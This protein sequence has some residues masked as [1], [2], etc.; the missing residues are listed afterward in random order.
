MIKPNF[1]FSLLPLFIIFI[2]SCKKSDNNIIS[3]GQISGLSPI[4][5]MSSVD[6][7]LPYP[8]FTNIWGVLTTVTIRGNYSDTNGIRPIY[9]NDATAYF[10]YL[11]GDGNAGSVTVNN[12]VLDT[13]PL[14]KNVPYSL[15][16]M[17][18]NQA[19]SD[20]LN[21]MTD[22]NW[23]VS[24][25]NNV[26]AISYNYTGSFPAFYG[27]LPFQLSSS[28]DYTIIF[29]STNTDGADSVYIA[30]CA[31]ET[32]G[33]GTGRVMATSP[34]STHGGSATLPASLIQEFSSSA[35]IQAYLEIIV[36]K[37]TIKTF[38]NKRYAFVKMNETIQNVTIN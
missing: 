30:I 17:N 20:S 24:G 14:T 34:V 27:T 6:T 5:N 4:P 21:F 13:F 32:G 26:P 38:G 1:Y 12:Y 2:C 8:Y 28:S 19:V 11:K 29:D 9:A 15:F 16:Y 37:Y 10:N 18:A 22:N 7:R 31:S 25:N 23:I 33:S 36:Y 3:Y 35:V